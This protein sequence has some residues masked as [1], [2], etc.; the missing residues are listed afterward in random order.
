VSLTP[1]TVP[2]L[3]RRCRRQAEELDNRALAR[4]WCESALGGAGPEAR[5]HLNAFLGWLDELAARRTTGDAVG[6]AVELPLLDADASG[7]AFLARLEVLARDPGPEPPRGATFVAALEQGEAA[8]LSL[9]LGAGLAAGAPASRPAL[10]LD[11]PPGLREMRLDGASVGAAA[12]LAL[13]SF[14]TGAPIPRGVVVTG[15]VGPGGELLP[16]PGLEAKVCCALR[17]RGDGA[18]VLVPAGG[19]APPGAE[20]VS[21]VAGLA[22]AVLGE[23]PPGSHQSVDIEGTVALGV[24]LLLKAGRPRSAR[25]ALQVA[26]DAI[27]Q[28]RAAGEDPRRL[29][30]EELICRWRLGALQTH[31]GE[32]SAALAML[33]PARALAET[34]WQEQEVDP[35]DY[36]GL[37]GT[38]AVLLRDTLRFDQAEALLLR[39]L[40]E[41]RALRQDRRARART[42]GNLGE[43][44]T[45][46]GQ[47]SRAEAALVEALEILR[48][49]YPDEAPRELCYLGNL[50]LCRDAD[51]AGLE[52]FDQGLEENQAV[53][54]GARANEAFLRHGR[55]R[56]LLGLGR[57]EE[58]EAEA[59]RVLELQP[60]EQPYPRQLALQTRGLA[61]L[62]RGDHEQGRR[63][64]RDAADPT[65]TPGALLGFGFATALAR[66]SLHLL[67]R[68]EREQALATAA[69]FVA[70]SAAYLDAFHHP[71]WSAGMEALIEGEELEALKEA[72]A[73]AVEIFPYR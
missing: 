63:D 6:V 32:L 47:H 69:D 61:R 14:H 73:A 64:L 33:E 30:R 2:A 55:A 41:Q 39:T 21:S 26:L 9:L 50:E 67:E 11:G 68:E 28:R 16:G 48:A 1:E 52:R 56:A 54:H 12:A 46:T 43:L 25:A 18:R 65:H 23:L 71:G 49:S 42:L 53:Q 35:A 13:I 7:E 22:R 20:P 44:W 3:L 17:E 24:H 10:R 72:L 5:Y 57:L 27:G 36:L 40:D 59:E 70:R 66:L 51:A 34:L 15:A 37:A 8:A 62:A 45:I 31:R 4:E 38:V 19:A 60:I 29:R 58:A